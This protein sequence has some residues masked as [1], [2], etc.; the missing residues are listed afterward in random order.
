[1]GIKKFKPTSPGRRGMTGYTFEEITRDKPEQSLLRPLRKKAG[2]NVHGRI[3]VHHRGGG[4]R[5]KYRL[6]DFRRNKFGIPA[7][8]DSIEYDP[9]RSARIALLVYVDGEKRYIIAPLGLKV[10]DKVISDKGPVELNVGNAT[11]LDNISVGTTVH[12]VELYPGRGGQLARAAGVVARVV[13]REG[14]YV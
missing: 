9:N 2:R 10:G 11:P 5:R 6:I 7:R 14:D 4:H 12:N 1:M 8:V 13:G 3:T